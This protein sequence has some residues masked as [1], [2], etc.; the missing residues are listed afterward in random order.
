[1]RK[2]LTLL[3][4]LLVIVALSACEVRNERQSSKQSASAGQQSVVPSDVPNNSNYEAIVPNDTSGE[5]ISREQAI[6]IALQAAGVDKA[7][8]FYI[9]AEL[10]RELGNLVWEVDFETREYEY[11]YDVNAHDGSIVKSERE[12]ND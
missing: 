5:T 12:L 7:S 3:L 9:E 2:P 4:A 8:A 11:S 10:D 1:M 6:N